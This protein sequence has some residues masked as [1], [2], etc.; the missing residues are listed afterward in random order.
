MKALLL[1]AFLMQGNSNQ[2]LPPPA[3]GCE[4]SINNPHCA[5]EVPINGLGILAI[6]GGVYA[7]KKLK[8][9]E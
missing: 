5:D 8:E 7:I 3:Q 2:P 1:I 4:N 6:A 9:K